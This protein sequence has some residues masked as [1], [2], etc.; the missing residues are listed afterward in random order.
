MDFIINENQLRA[1]LREQDESKM[2]TYMKRLYSFTKEVAN[3]VGK[4]Y[5]LNVKMLLT[6]GT[7][8]GGLI[9]PLDNFIRNGSFDVTDDQRYLILAGIASILFFNNKKT[10][11]EL[12]KKIEEEGLKN[13][14]N[15]VLKKSEELEEAFVNFLNGIKISVGTFLD[16]VAYAF[17]IPIITDIQHYISTSSDPRETGKII[18]ER[19]IASGVVVMGAETLS[20]LMVKLIRKFK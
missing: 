13:T 6:W 11:K 12:I 10:T 17:L 4:K 8:V 20:A 14:F 19:L 15:I 18:L 3:R 5:D 1:I 7:S 2:T 16:T 9:L